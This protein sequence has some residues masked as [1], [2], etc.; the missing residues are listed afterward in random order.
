MLARLGLSALLLV[1]VAACDPKPAELD[2]AP[3]DAP[4][5]DGAPKGPDAGSE[6]DGGAA[7]D[8]DAAGSSVLG[9]V[10]P[11]GVQVIND[12]E[13]VIAADYTSPPKMACL[14]FQ[15]E[16]TVQ[17]GKLDDGV[18]VAISEAGWQLVRVQGN[19]QYFERP[20]PGGDCAEVAVVSV[21]TDRLQAVVDHVRGGKPAGTAVW[22]AYSIPASTRAAC[23]AD[24]M[25][26]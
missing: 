6:L 19:E 1:S 24:R 7:A 10:P 14:L 22:L 5:L 9:I 8:L 2:G 17:P 21:L 11:M 16:D 15:T 4:A 13:K 3:S 18:F 12:C 26:K 25:G 23:G 20:Q